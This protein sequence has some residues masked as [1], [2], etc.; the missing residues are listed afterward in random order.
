LLCA[1]QRFQAST[2]VCVV[3]LMLMFGG[4][5]PMFC[6]YTLGAW[7]AAS[8][9]P[10][11]H[12]VPLVT[13]GGT[14]LGLALSPA[15]GPAIRLVCRL[16]VML[17]V[18]IGVASA[19]LAS[20]YSTELDRPLNIALTWALFAPLNLGCAIGMVHGMYR[21][22]EQPRLLLGRA[23]ALG[24]LLTFLSGSGMIVG[25]SP[26]LL[27]DPISSWQD[28]YT[29]GFVMTAM[30]F[31]VLPLSMTPDVRDRLRCSLGQPRWR[32]GL[33]GTRQ[34]SSCDDTERGH[35]QPILIASLL[36]MHGSLR[37]PEECLREV[38]HNFFCCALDATVDVRAHAEAPV[39]PR[40]VASLCAVRRKAQ[41][42]AVDAFVSCSTL[43]DEDAQWHAMA[44]WAREFA[45][46][47]KRSPSVWYEP[48]CVQEGLGDAERVALCPLMVMGCQQ[49]VVLAGPTYA[50]R[51][52]ALVEVLV[53][54][55]TRQGGADI[56]VLPLVRQLQENAAGDAGE[57]TS[58]RALLRSLKQVDLATADCDHPVDRQRVLGALKSASGTLDTFNRTLAD[59]LHNKCHK[60]LSQGAGGTLTTST[61]S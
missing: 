9:G 40:T 43:D 56:H 33:V 24:R 20:A 15:N 55:S 31:V 23:W 47:R 4:W 51:L 50:S 28:P 30:S 53:F 59:L 52:L 18:A 22:G 41:L 7:P 19:K 36:Q 35:Q 16:L 12:Y 61:S 39:Q 49:L 57:G 26:L 5:V 11:T 3:G 17:W 38:Q 37:S 54:H 25:L 29:Y 6:Q 14:I 60:G 21:F 2:L 27:R 8:M 44:Q 42:G 46:R 58:K 13:L 32:S 10:Y 45:E 1:L 34:P 48:V